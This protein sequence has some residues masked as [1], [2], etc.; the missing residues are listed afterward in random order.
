[1]NRR[2][3]L[4]GLV[5]TPV[6]GCV[7]THSGATDS[8]GIPDHID[9]DWRLPGYDYRLRNYT[10]AAS[11]PTGEID[12]IWRVEGDASYSPPV[13]ADGDVFVGAD[14]GTVRALDAREGD[15]R[16]AVSVGETASRPQVGARYVY[17]T[18]AED[19]VALS[20]EDGS[21]EWRID[22]IPTISQSLRHRQG[23][24]SPGGFLYTP[25]GFYLVRESEAACPADAD[26]D[27]CPAG[28]GEGP[29][30]A[31][32]V[33][34]H[35]PD[36]GELLWEEPIYDPLSTHL[37][38]SAD[39]LFVSSE[40]VGTAPWVLMPR[41]GRVTE[42]VSRISHGPAEHC[43]ADGVVYGF[44]SWNGSFQAQQVTA[45]GVD[46]IV[47]ERIPFSAENLATDGRRCYISSSDGHG[48][49]GIACL[50]PDGTELWRHELDTVVGMPTIA[51]DVVL[52]RDS[53]T[54]YGVDP[55]EGSVFWTHSAV[56]MGSEFAIVDDIIYTAANGMV[57]ALRSS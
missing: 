37:F 41:E 42:D 50:S 27:T 16:W 33:S 48:T 2:S 32:L 54:L 18:T 13:L 23:T 19:T 39:S 8:S 56:D 28:A 10:S 44:D 25:H 38:G 57:R 9:S 30:T 35:D 3:F 15:E 1:M 31:A 4:G 52:Y 20:P 7:T 26:E 40:T 45:D 53:D 5:A 46:T 43:Y 29:T 51:N 36:T 21:Q 22:V 34:R 49:T 24:P 11:G 12:E 6:A 55:A 17:V 14:D 47:S